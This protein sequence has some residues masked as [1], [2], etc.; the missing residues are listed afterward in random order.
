VLLFFL[1]PDSGT[2][3]AGSFLT[4]VS[5][6]L[7]DSLTS[8]SSQHP[9]PATTSWVAPVSTSWAAGGAMPQVRR[10]QSL[11]ELASFP[12]SH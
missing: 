11:S 12:S 2:L 10:P 7:K 4:T 6:S 3:I 1:N 8:A 9:K 5:A